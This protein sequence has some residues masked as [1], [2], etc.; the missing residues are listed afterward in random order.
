MIVRF[1]LCFL[2][3]FQNRFVFERL[4]LQNIEFE[5]IVGVL[6]GKRRIHQEFARAGI[7]GHRKGAAT[8]GDTSCNTSG[9]LGKIVFLRII[10]VIALVVVIFF[11]VFVLV[12]VVGPFVLEFPG[13]VDRAESFA[14]KF[15]AGRDRALG[16]RI[17][18]AVFFL[19]LQIARTFLPLGL[20]S[21]D[22]AGQK[23]AGCKAQGRDGNRDRRTGRKAERRSG[24]RQDRIQT[25][26]SDDA[27]EKAGRED[28]AANA[29]ESG[30]PESHDRRKGGVRA[31][32]S[33]TLCTFLLLACHAQTTFLLRP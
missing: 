32:R 8:S 17:G 15:P 4:Q 3:G 9:G 14:A 23:Q 31:D 2:D 28:H 5:S 16:R 6:A 25:D 29:K 27:F 18:M 24:S 7:V 30:K 20:G 11:F 12:F 26:G 22:L 19:E 10:G 1:G 13:I 21:H 33:S